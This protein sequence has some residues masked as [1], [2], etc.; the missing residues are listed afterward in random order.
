M[1]GRPSLAEDPAKPTAGR[2]NGV[3]VTGRVKSAGFVELSEDIGLTAYSAILPRVA[4]LHL[5]I[6]KRSMLCERSVVAKKSIYQ[7]ISATCSMGLNPMSSWRLK[8]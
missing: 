1:R 3:F 6:P 5:L 7:S 4:L 8:I 2:D